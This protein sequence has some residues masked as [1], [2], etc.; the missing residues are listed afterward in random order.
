MS[1]SPLLPLLPVMACP[2]SSNAKTPP[3]AGTSATSAASTTAAASAVLKQVL[4]KTTPHFPPITH[5][6]GRAIPILEKKD[7]CAGCSGARDEE[8]ED[9]P[10]LLCDGKG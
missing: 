7:V 1:V 10:I 4:G 3:G 2:V 8:A 6:Y 5:M 9:E